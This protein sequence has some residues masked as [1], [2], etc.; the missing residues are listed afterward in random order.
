MI[1]HAI[2]H[3]VR[4]LNVALEPFTQVNFNAYVHSTNHYGGKPQRYRQVQADFHGH[5]AELLANY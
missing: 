3:Y 1:L 4:R 5:V 2:L